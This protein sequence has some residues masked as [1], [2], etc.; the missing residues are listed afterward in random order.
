MVASWC[1]HFGVIWFFLMAGQGN[2]GALEEGAYPTCAGCFWGIFRF[3]RTA[4]ARGTGPSTIAAFFRRA[5]WS[6]TWSIA[7]GGRGC[8]ST[9]MDWILGNTGNSWVLGGRTCVFVLIRFQGI[10]PTIPTSGHHK[11]RKN[12]QNIPF[13]SFDVIWNIHNHRTSFFHYLGQENRENRLPFSD[14]GGLP[15][16]DEGPGFFPGTKGG[17]RVPKIT[18]GWKWIEI[19][20]FFRLVVARKHERHLYCIN[21]TPPNSFCCLCLFHMIY[22]LSYQIGPILSISNPI[23]SYW[24]RFVPGGFR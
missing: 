11:N 2:L 19:N 20:M 13:V 1:I 24:S 21:L 3:S 10:K 7:T 18:D 22:I 14:F 15:S 12:F 16:F 6:T 17:L 5:P 9:S 4:A 8:G 23:L